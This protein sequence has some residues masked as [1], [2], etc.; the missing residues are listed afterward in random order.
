MALSS[1]SSVKGRW[2]EAT[3]RTLLEDSGLTA[4][5][6]FETQQ[7][8]TGEE[9]G[10]FRPDFVIK[11]PDGAELAVDSK[12]SLDWYIKAIEETDET[13]KGEYIKKFAQDIRSRVKNLASKEY[14]RHLDKKIPY[15]VMFVPSEAAIRAAFDQDKDLYRDAQNQKVMLASPTTTVPLILLIAQAW[16]QY[17]SAENAVKVIEE[18]AV[19]GERLKTFINHTTGIGQA[20]SQATERYNKMA[21]SWDTRVHPKID[22]INGLSG[23]M[24][25][26]PSIST[27]EAEPRQPNKI[28]VLD[29]PQTGE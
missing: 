26:L 19:L 29:K 11:M 2:G 3:L 21:A 7:T 4:G 5:I 25:E 16:R 20:L 22:Q 8:L 23:N 12:A 18:V 6:N 9:G 14:Q 17:N 13:R 28:A 10:L 1:S 15:V 24:G 27:I